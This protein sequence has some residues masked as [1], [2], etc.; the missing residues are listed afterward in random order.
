ML[1]GAD[2]EKPV[3]GRIP[4]WRRALRT[5]VGPIVLGYLI[6]RV[7]ESVVRI[8]VWRSAWQPAIDALRRYNKTVGVGTRVAPHGTPATSKMASRRTAT[9]HHTGRR[10]GRHYITP[11]WAER[12]GQ[13][14]FIQLPYGTD[15]DWCRN[16]HAGGG[17]TLEHKGVRY[18]TIAPMI[19]PAAVAR[20]H[21]PPATRRMQRLIGARSYLRLDI[22]QKDVIPV[23]SDS[24]SPV[25]H[26]IGDAHT[27]VGS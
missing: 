13:S 27:T 7:F 5:A 4:P 9:V 17:C 16:V 14:F 1:R 8:A 6:Y 18:H 12:A 23:A 22:N 3:T 2:M 15:V 20:P 24:P 26:E 19:V 11:V 21:L 10:S 25:P